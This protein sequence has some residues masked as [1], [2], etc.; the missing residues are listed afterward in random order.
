MLLLVGIVRGRDDLHTDRASTWIYVAVNLAM[1]ALLT[2]LVATM[3]PRRAAG[4][5]P[6]VVPGAGT[7]AS[8][9]P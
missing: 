9:A 2:W 6:P 7:R 4:S 5:R 8:T 3:S 1:L